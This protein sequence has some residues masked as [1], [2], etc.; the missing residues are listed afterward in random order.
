MGVEQ[1]NL[2]L[3]L[4]VDLCNNLLLPLS[5]SLSLYL[6][7]TY[8]CVEQGH[9]HICKLY[10]VM[11]TLAYGTRTLPCTW[12]SSI[13][14]LT[15]PTKSTTMVGSTWRKHMD[16]REK[17]LMRHEIIIV[18]IGGWVLKPQSLAIAFTQRMWKV[19][20]SD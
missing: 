4:F 5:L 10:F 17:S 7:P 9:D 6:L 14:E 15:P 16:D 12:T 1:L 20:E 18:E 11:Y 8:L 13:E 3:C 2:I 19:R